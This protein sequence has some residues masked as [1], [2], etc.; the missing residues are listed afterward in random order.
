M[1]ACMK[2]IPDEIKNLYNFL[3]FADRMYIKLR[4][5]LCPFTVLEHFLPKSG[6]IIDLGCGYGMLA[7]LAALNSAERDVYGFDLSQKRINIAK[8]TVKNRNNLHFELKNVRD[9]KLNSCDA[10]VM[11]DFLHHIP[12]KEQENLI[13]QAK[14]KLKK[15][16]ILIIQD[17]DKRPLFKYLFAVT[18]DNLLNLFPRLYYRKANS[19]KNML[20]RN[21]FSVSVVRVDK[22][23]PLPDI[24]FI[25]KKI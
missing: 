6:K 11:S 21:S 24:L 3:G 16:G 10:I 12:Y 25:C 14:D 15:N 23:L 5:R 1:C 22:K 8:R 20:E 4:W 7:N 9:L 19:F 13:R 18:L 2:K 17:I